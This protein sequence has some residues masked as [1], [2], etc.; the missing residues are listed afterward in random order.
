VTDALTIDEI[1]AR[2]SGDVPLIDAVEKRAHL[3]QRHPEDYYIEP[4]WTSERL[5][6]TV[7]FE[8]TI[9]DP[10]CGSGRVVRAARQ[11]RDRV[12]PLG[13]N[14]ITKALGY[15]IVKRS[16]ECHD[17]IEDF[18]TSDYE[19]DNIVSNPPFGLCGKANKKSRHSEDFAFVKRTLVTAEKKVALLL[20]LPWM[21]G[22]DKAA[23]LQTTPLEQVLVLTP[24]PSMPPGP[25]IEA[26]EDPGGGT[27]DFAWFI[28]NRAY[29]GKPT[30]GWLNRDA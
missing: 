1:E 17:D 21:T 27:E 19:T 9:V 7:A 22:A 8:G 18:L 11:H 15:D 10:A 16:K 24:R 29:K 6:Q 25:V 20:P 3:F 4:S 26:G 2:I 5:F 14:R 13:D 12:K 23:F 30:L 28:W